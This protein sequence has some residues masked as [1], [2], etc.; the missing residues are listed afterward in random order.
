MRIRPIWDKGDILA[1]RAAW[2]DYHEFGD[3]FAD[4][5]IIMLG[6]VCEG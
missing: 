6:R 3:D 1:M 2:G 5:L 4:R